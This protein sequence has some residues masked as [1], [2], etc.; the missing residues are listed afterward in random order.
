MDRIKIPDDQ[1]VPLDSIAA[2]VQGLRIAF[3]NVF[4]LTHPDGTWTL[5]DTALPYTD[6]I[7]RRWVEKTFQQV[8]NA[9]VLSHGHFDHVSGAEVL[10]E[11]WNVP[12]YAHALERPYLNG[13]REYPPPNAGAGGGLMSVLSPLLPRGPVNLGARLH[14][15]PERDESS[16]PEMPGWTIL[17]TPGHTA[18]HVSFFREEDRTLL[19]ADAF[20]TTKPESFFEAAIAQKSE[21]HGPPAYFTSD[22]NQARTSVQRLAGLSP[23]TIA[24]GHG[25][26]ITGVSVPDELRTLAARFDEVAVPDNK[27]AKA[28]H[29]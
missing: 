28:Q 25:K 14:D 4:A 13:E 9:I 24:P 22:W 26:P 2:G 23:L 5:I 12:I 15:L 29:R 19:P 3:V 21:L 1:V 17:N 8:P 10:A 7:V 6:G 16:L 20:C 18:G 11:L 27:R